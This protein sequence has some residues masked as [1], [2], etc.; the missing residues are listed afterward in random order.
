MMDLMEE[1]R[2]EKECITESINDKEA[3]LCHFLIKHPNDDNEELRLIRKQ[4]AIAHKESR[5]YTDEEHRKH[6][7][8]LMEAA[9]TRMRRKLYV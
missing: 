6:W 8:D 5:M 7:R 3:E 2:I 1:Q 4:L 9:D